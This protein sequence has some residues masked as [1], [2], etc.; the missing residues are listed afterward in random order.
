MTTVEEVFE[1]LNF[2]SLQTLKKVLDSG[3]ITCD[4]KEIAKLVKRKAVRQVQVPAYKFG[5]KIAVCGI[6]DRW[7]CD[8]IDF[9][10]YSI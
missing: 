9:T 3:D 1:E 10:A 2:P 6:T 8:L 7:F 5:R 4:R